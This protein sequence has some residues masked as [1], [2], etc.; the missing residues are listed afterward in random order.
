MAKGYPHGYVCLWYGGPDVTS[1][2]VIK[3]IPVCRDSSSN[4]NSDSI[5]G[6]HCLLPA[7]SKESLI[8]AGNSS[9]GGN[10][11]HSLLLT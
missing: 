7:I 10:R 2:S 1:T 5:V 4:S 11:T 6:D 8:E 9:N 3:V